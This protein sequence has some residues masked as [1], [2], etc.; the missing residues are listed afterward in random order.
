MSNFGTLSTGSMA[1]SR[2]TVA[3]IEATTTTDAH[4]LESCT[5]EIVAEG[6]KVRLHGVMETLRT[7]RDMLISLGAHMRS[8][9]QQDITLR[10][11]EYI[12]QRELASRQ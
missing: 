8:T 10:T 1:A 5:A 11:P 6:E 3:E 7:K 4:Y 2:V 12:E 9:M